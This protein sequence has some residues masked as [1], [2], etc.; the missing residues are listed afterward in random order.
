MLDNGVI[1][2]FNGVFFM[3]NGVLNVELLSLM[4]FFNESNYC[5]HYIREVLTFLILKNKD[6]KMIMAANKVLS[7]NTFTFLE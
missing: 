5:F 7:K 2:M 6:G 4:A 1:F 3:F